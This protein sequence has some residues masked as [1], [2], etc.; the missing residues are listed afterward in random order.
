MAKRSR[1]VPAGTPLSEYGGD[2]GSKQAAVP[3][4]VKSTLKAGACAWTRLDPA[5]AMTASIG[6]SRSSP[7]RRL[8]YMGHH[9]NAPEAAILEEARDRRIK[10]LLCR[11][12][13]LAMVPRV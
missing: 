2:F 1:L 5:S 8:G 13:S 9:A 10:C 3:C 12:G 7:A 6:Q 11:V 4:H